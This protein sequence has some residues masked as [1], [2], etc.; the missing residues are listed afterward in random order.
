MMFVIAS[1]LLALFPMM[2]I[3]ATIGEVIPPIDKNGLSEWLFCLFVINFLYFLKKG[4]DF[5]K[6]LRYNKYN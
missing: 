4:V 3:V 2:L 1:P 5:Y 6:T